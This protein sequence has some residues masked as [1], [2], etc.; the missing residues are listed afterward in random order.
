[1]C[2]QHLFLGRNIQQLLVISLSFFA[3]EQSWFRKTI[4]RG[5]FWSLHCVQVWRWYSPDSLPQGK[6]LNLQPSDGNGEKKR[7]LLILFLNIFGKLLDHPVLP[8]SDTFCQLD[9]F[10]KTL[11]TIVLMVWPYFRLILLIFP[12]PVCNQIQTVLKTSKSFWCL[13]K[14]GYFFW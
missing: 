4:A 11:A 10:L 13:L 2:A 6:P 1:M 14:L 12:K 5:R 8:D 3:G 9:Y 7:H